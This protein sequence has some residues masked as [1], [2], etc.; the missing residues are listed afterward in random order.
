MSGAESR[1]NGTPGRARLRPMTGA[2]LLTTAFPPRE[3]LL[4]PWLPAKGLTMV[5]G[6]RGVGKTHVAL[7]IAWAAAS[8]SRFLRW[9]APGA[10]RVVIIDGEMPG[11][12]LKARLAEIVANAWQGN[13]EE[14][15]E[16]ISIVAADL[17][18]RAINLADE[19]DQRELEPL[20]EG[21]DLIIVDNISTLA[22]YGRENEAES[23]DPMQRWALEQRRRGR[24]VLFVHHAGKGGAQRGTSR[25]EDVL[26]TVIALR[27]PA[28]YDQA[29]GARFEVHY[30]KARGFHGRDAEPFDASF[31]SGGWTVRDVVDAEVERI[32]AMRE[33]GMT[34]REI[35]EEM[36]EHRSWVERRLRRAAAATKPEG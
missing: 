18:E 8:G 5:Y 23:W 2:L 26:D 35:A 34:I 30:E 25:K 27:E 36:G 24:T 29:Q 21:A 9:R 10:R 20:L 33:E 17:Q 19:A 11:E 16:R 3:M 6:R 14:A 7:G 15:L 4:E 12:T 22:A 32:R 1:A 31:G 28:D 13:A